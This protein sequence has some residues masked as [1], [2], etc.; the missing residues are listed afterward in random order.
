MLGEEPTD[1]EQNKRRDV[2]GYSSCL[3]AQ[4]SEQGESGMEK[5]ESEKNSTVVWVDVDS[6]R[7]K[8][9]IVSDPFLLQCLS[10]G[11]L[12]NTNRPYC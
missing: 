6:S 5:T 12:E 1:V 8:P 2:E 10:K 9:T 3:L 7:E 4:A 11:D